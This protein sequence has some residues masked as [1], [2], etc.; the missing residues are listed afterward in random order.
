VDFS[1]SLRKW[2]TPGFKDAFE[3]NLAENDEA[4]PLDDLCEAGGGPD[5]QSC[6][7]FDFENAREAA[8]NIIATAICYFEES[9]PGGCR[10][11]NRTEKRIGRLIVTIDRRSGQ[12]DVE[13]DPN[14]ERRNLENY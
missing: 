2:G 8:D 12:A 1:R 6:A 10:E 9:I 5:M 11:L 7:D 4:L 3:T 13:I 14:F